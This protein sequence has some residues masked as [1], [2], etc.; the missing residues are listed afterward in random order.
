M[1]WPRNEMTLRACF[2]SP[3]RAISGP[4]VP[5]VWGCVG[6]ARLSDHPPMRSFSVAR[7]VPARPRSGSPGDGGRSFP[8]AA[9]RS[10]RASRQLPTYRCPARASNPVYGK[11]GCADADA[12]HGDATDRAFAKGRDK[13]SACAGQGTVFTQLFE[14]ICERQFVVSV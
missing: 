3:I 11:A 14:K 1:F 10:C 7:R 12:I 5:M 9:L 13:E 4:G 8:Q 6:C 2:L